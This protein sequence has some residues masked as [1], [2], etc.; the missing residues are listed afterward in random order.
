MSFI[1]QQLYRKNQ[2]QIQ[3]QHSQAPIK[4]LL[5][6]QL[7][8]TAKTYAEVMA[9]EKLEM[10]LSQ[11]KQ[12][13]QFLIV[14]KQQQSN[15]LLQELE[16]KYNNTEKQVEFETAKQEYQDIQIRLQQMLS[17]ENQQFIQSVRTHKMLSGLNQQI[18]YDQSQN[19]ILEFLKKFYFSSLI[20]FHNVLVEDRR[21][22]QE[23]QQQQQNPKIQQKGQQLQQSMKVYSQRLSQYLYFLLVREDDPNLKL[24]LSFVLITRTQNNL[25]MLEILNTYIQSLIQ[26]QKQNVIEGLKQILNIFPEFQDLFSMIIRAFIQRTNLDGR[27]QLDEKQFET[28]LLI[29][30]VSI[31]RPMNFVQALSEAS[32]N[33]LRQIL[34]IYKSDCSKEFLISQQSKLT[35]LLSIEVNQQIIND[36]TSFLEQ[37]RSVKL[38]LL[39]ERII[40]FHQKTEKNICLQYME[41]KV[42]LPQDQELISKHT[43]FAIQN[44]NYKQPPLQLPQQLQNQIFQPSQHQVRLQTNPRAVQNVYQFLHILSIASKIDCNQ[45]NTRQYNELSSLVSDEVAGFE[46]S[47]TPSL[48]AT[49]QKIRD[50]LVYLL[51]LQKLELNSF[52]SLWYFSE[53]LKLYLEKATN[54]IQKNQLSKQTFPFLNSILSTYQNPDK[55]SLKY[56][57]LKTQILK[58]LFFQPKETNHIDFYYM[59]KLIENYDGTNQQNFQQNVKN[60]YKMEFKQYLERLKNQG[61][62]QV[63]NAINLIFQTQ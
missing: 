7:E 43:Y 13:N 21:S 4:I 9:V 44:K 27:V 54:E 6:N 48:F 32:S 47:Y 45:M 39:I 33:I 41:F 63:K 1:N 3:N 10:R 31:P 50:A 62:D 55:E 56:A 2:Q 11:L 14:E 8:R 49:R 61:S 51:Q 18:V 29:L 16:Q 46:T 42:F 53:Q 37:L 35:K 23:G 38:K 34:L 36:L 5:Y 30:D 22:D 57:Q 28:I 58:D 17:I 52:T 59:M 24:L 25:T 26:A 20:N 40:E 19:N 60:Y 15:Q 12:L